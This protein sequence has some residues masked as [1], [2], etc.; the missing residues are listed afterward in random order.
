[1]SAKAI[2]NEAMMKDREFLNLA[3]ETGTR[4]DQLQ[5]ETDPGLRLSWGAMNLG[6]AM[7]AQAMIEHLGTKDELKL[8]KNV[9]SAEDSGVLQTIAVNLA[10]RSFVSAMELCA[11]AAWRFR[12][13]T[14][15]GGGH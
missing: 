2:N 7:A 1:M 9:L 4:M 5:P 13:G 14:A 10:V 15:L 6:G 3:H 8:L 12:P 11:A